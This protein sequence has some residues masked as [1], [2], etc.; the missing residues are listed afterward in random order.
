MR[1]TGGSLAAASFRFGTKGETLERLKP[2]LTTARLCDQAIVP[3]ADWRAARGE[4]IAALLDRFGG[5]RL[6]VRSSSRREDGWDHSGAG[7]FE[8]ATGIAA[9]PGA[10]AAA[11]RRVIASYG[12]DADS[13]HV[14]V[15]PMVE[16]VALSGV[17]LTRDLDTGGP[18]YVINY[19]DF[20]GRTDTVTGGAESKTV[21]VHR[22]NLEALHSPR[23]RGIIAA[24]REIERITGAEE[25]D[26]EFCVTAD[27]EVYV[28]QVR[29]LAARRRWQPVPDAAIDDAI[30]AVR[31]EVEALQRP[32]AGLAGQTTILGEMPDWNPAEMIGNTPRPLA[33]SLYARQITD[34]AWSVARARMGYRDV[35]HRLMPALAG[36]PYIDV[37][38]SL[39]S[40]LPNGL[41]TAVAGRLV[42]AELAL[43]AGRTELH[44]RIEF[45]VALT[46]RDVRFRDQAALL[47][48]AGLAPGDV[49]E[50]GTALGALTEACVGIGPAGI[51]ALLTAPRRLLEARPPA[52]GD[53]TAWLTALLD[54]TVAQG[55]VPFS[56]LARHAFVGV[57]FLRALVARGALEGARA[58]LFLRSIRTVASDVVDT[59]AQVSDGQLD[60]ATFLTRYGH[61]RPGTYDILSWRYD[62][63]P[64]LY[65]GEAKRMPTTREHFALTAA[66]RRAIGACLV[67]EGFAFDAE[68][69]FA[70]S[71]AAIAA[72]EEAKY[73]FTRGISDALL[74]I[75]RWGE[76][77]GLTREDLAHLPIARILEAP[78]DAGALR[79]EIAA[80][81]ERHLLARALRLPHLIVEPDDLDVVRPL[82]GRPTFITGRRVAAP[83][84]HLAS[85]GICT[86]TGQLVLIES[87][88]PGFDWIFSHPIAGLITRY[89]G[90]NSHMAIRCAEFGLPAA[91]GCGERLFG[92]LL[93]AS[94][95]E[96]DCANRRVIG[97]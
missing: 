10:L 25:L 27:I 78:D 66:E 35:P 41:D 37:R 61:L 97:R 48:E 54:R 18:Y 1:A 86:L 13:Q 31:A 6:A 95:I 53:F 71:A 45:E 56:I 11:F 74:A 42:D 79:G 20:S 40:F 69:L 76:A 59:M 63:R 33:L 30:A 85:T 5:L 36:H 94:M 15:Q 2:L 9:E 8:S 39:N 75:G 87:A 70:Y 91:I 65:L 62:E 47:V 14:L 90:V 43:L 96:L 19:D 17:V 23:M 4:T 21:L 88:D 57:A 38:L 46:C 67:E 26:I 68:S 89:G 81:A 64:A 32:V 28:L 44:D 29:P 72:R 58:D 82:R 16:N 24:A 49:T 55:T 12:D 83:A 7:A 3:V 34:R 80:A 92:E 52:D 77:R 93:R 22:A 50:I 51:D 73:A 60:E 84:I